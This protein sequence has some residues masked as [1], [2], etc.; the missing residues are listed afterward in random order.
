MKLNGYPF[1]ND[2]GV[3]VVGINSQGIPSLTWSTGPGS[4]K[5]SGPASDS[6]VSAPPNEPSAFPTPAAV[7]IAEDGIIVGSGPG[8]EFLEGFKDNTDVFRVV[9]EKL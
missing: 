3:A 8:S 7:G 2:R 1:R 6:P 5:D 4:R 9:S